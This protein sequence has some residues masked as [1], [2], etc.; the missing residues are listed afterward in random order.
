[1]TSSARSMILA[2][3]LTPIAFTVLFIFAAQGW[4]HAPEDGARQICKGWVGLPWR[5]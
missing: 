5:A 3:M 1:M 4:R 2:G